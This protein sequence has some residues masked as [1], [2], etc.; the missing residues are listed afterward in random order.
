MRMR[1]H[2]KSAASWVL[3]AMLAAA[4]LCALLGPGFS[5]RLRSAVGSV[6]APLGDGGMYLATSV[7][8]RGE[9]IG[10]RGLSPQEARRLADTNDRLRRSLATLEA[11]NAR[12]IGERGELSRLYGAIPY[13]QWELVP[14]RVVAADSLPYGRSRLINAGRSRGAAA[15]EAVTTRSLLTDRSKA[16]PPNLA[17]ITGS[18]LAGRI[19][20][21]GAFTARLQLVIDRGFRTRARVHRAVDGRR[22]T[23][24]EGGLATEQPLSGDRNRAIPV[25][26]RGDGTA[27]LVEDVNAYHAIAPGDWLMTPGDDAF[28][29]AQVPIGRVIEVI[30]DP[31]RRGLFVSLRVEPAAD[32]DILREVYLVVPA[33]TS[34]GEGIR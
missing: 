34:A 31:K 22:I 16:L 28:L 18:A 15:D 23:V 7:E 12:L 3:T 1:L 19:V 24:M 6:L 26:A 14:A 21:A 4:G 27:L 10:Q 5:G 17:A 30:D 33:T 11:E 20:E 29:P 13:G 9:T 2:G 32:L 25:E 8:S